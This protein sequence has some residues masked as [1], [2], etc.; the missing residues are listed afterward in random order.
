MYRLRPG[1]V[2]QVMSLNLRGISRDSVRT[3]RFL[4]AGTPGGRKFPFFLNASSPP[5]DNTPDT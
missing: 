3:E 5:A 4:W 2:G 1:K